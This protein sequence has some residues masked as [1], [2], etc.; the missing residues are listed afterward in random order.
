MSGIPSPSPLPAAHD[1]RDTNTTSLL[2]LLQTSRACTFLFDI[3]GEQLCITA[4]AST[5][6]RLPQST[7]GARPC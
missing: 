4:S 5:P 2:T 7:E 3:R 6:A 1:C